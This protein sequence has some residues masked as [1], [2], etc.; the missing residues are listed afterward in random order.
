M[1]KLSTGCAALLTAIVLLLSG[2]F[3]Y[4]PVDVGAVRVGQDV[5]IA[6]TRAGL[7]ELDEFA[8]ARPYNVALGPLLEGTIASRDADRLLVRLPVLGSQTA[9]YQ[10][11]SDAQVPISTGQIVQIESREFDRLGTGLFVAGA[12]GAL[13]VA[14]F[15]FFNVETPPGVANPDPPPSDETRIPLF[16]RSR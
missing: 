7:R 11:P 9:L 3:T 15:K 4:V 13:V 14:I 6:L 16:N 5:R 12:V 10:A 2:C 8:E 1:N